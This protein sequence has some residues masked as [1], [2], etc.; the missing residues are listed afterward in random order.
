MRFLWLLT[1]VSAA[2]VTGLAFAHVLEMPQKM[3][4][5]G[6]T[7]SE[8][9]RSLYLYFGYVGGPLE[10]LAVVLAVLLAW[11][12]RGGGATFGWSV[13]GAALLALGLIEWA[14]VVQ[15][16]NTVMATWSD[17]TLPPEWTSTRL[18]WELG[19]VGHFLLLGAGFVALL[20]SAMTAAGMRGPAHR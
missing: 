12:L 5:D 1:L 7:Y 16:A 15:S 11:R 8:V 9:Q 20:W 4:Y 10:I 19:H 18:Q 17:G 3:A 14:I 13:A 2:L 6:P